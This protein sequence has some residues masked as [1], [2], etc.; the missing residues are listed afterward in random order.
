MGI[1]TPRYPPQPRIALVCI[2]FKPVARSN[3]RWAGHCVAV[4]SV[5]TWTAPR[6]FQQS[7]ALDSAAAL[8]LVIACKKPFGTAS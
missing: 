3:D 1:Y 5:L 7:T 2:K 8:I 4:K 6:F